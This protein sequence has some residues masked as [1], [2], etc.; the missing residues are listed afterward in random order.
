MPGTRQVGATIWLGL[1]L[2]GS[3]TLAAQGVTGAAI[4]G[5]VGNTNGDPVQD[6]NVLVT[7]SSTGERWQ[8]ATGTNGRFFVEHLSVGGPY[9]IDVHAIGFA[10]ASQG[11]I[12]LSLGERLT[13]GFSLR[14]V[15]VELAELTVQAAVD[16]LI[17]AGRTGPAQIVSDST[18]LRLPSHRDYTDLARLAPQVNYGSFALSFAGQPDRLNGLQVDGSTNNDLFN[19]SE[20][21]NGTIAGFPDLTIPTVESLEEVQIVTAP[22]DVRF[23]GFA[24]GLINAV[25]KSGSNIL[26][27]AAYTYFENQSLTGRDASGARAPDF[28][29]GEAGVSVGGPCMIGWPS[30]STRGSA[31]RAHPSRFPRPAPTPP[32]VRTRQASGSATAAPSGSAT[33]CG[34]ATA[35]M[36][37]TSR[38]GRTA[39]RAAACSRR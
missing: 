13:T 15:A 22:F 36:R 7:N 26:R 28:S 20:T 6:A 18:M 5:S 33:S 12:L 37:A 31:G 21:G 3:A 2:W 30:F 25:T 10:P 27:G 9:R 16:P 17:N 35:S 39:C 38:P 23:G 8:R 29:Q 11:G 4:Q 14:H 19:T 32:A 34:T 24:G 1:V